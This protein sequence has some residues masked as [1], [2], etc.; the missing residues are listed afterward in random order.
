MKVT[1]DQRCFNIKKDRLVGRACPD[2]GTGRS[3]SE[4][5]GQ[6]GRD[7]LDG[8]AADRVVELVATAQLI[9]VPACTE[10]EVRARTVL[11]PGAD[12]VP[13]GP[14]VEP[15]FGTDR[16]LVGRLVKTVLLI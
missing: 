7:R 16:V 5:E 1:P 11:E 9:A 13:A 8:G 12:Q 3:R 14:L 15:I 6:A 2:R 10:A 4:V